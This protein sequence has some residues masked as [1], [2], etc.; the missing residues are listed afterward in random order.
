MRSPFIS[1]I[2]ALAVALMTAGCAQTDTGITTAVKSKFAAD[3]QVKAYQIDVDTRD[4]VVTL[5]GS[6]DTPA[7]KTRAVELAR[8]TDG[9]RSVTDNI[10][11]SG[12]LGSA[13]PSIPDAA[14]ATLSDGGITAL[15]K[16]KLLG[17][18]DVSGLKIDVDT[19]NGVVTL[20][21]QVRTQAERDEAIRLT[22]EVDG[23]KSVQDQLTIVP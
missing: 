11:V 19:E 5:K 9:V 15:V 16:S 12:A 23:V 1:W 18:P 20:K 4:K 22:R 17:D 2:P 3:D 13:S 8:N 21:G 6:V 14:Q 10:T 7:A